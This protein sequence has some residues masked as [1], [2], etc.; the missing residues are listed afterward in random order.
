MPRASTER[1]LT[2]TDAARA[3]G[4][5]RRTLY[6]WVARGEVATVRKSGAM[7]IRREEVERITTQRQKA[8]V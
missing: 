7:G 2:M 8:A 3:I 6:Y 1:I 5:S 4:I